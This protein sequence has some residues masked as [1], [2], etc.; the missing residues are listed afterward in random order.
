[1]ALSMKSA[2]A[3]C[4]GIALAVI[5]P[6]LSLM[7]AATAIHRLPY[8][9]P[10]WSESLLAAA[11]GIF[12]SLPEFAITGALTAL[13][14]FAFEAAV[15]RFGWTGHRFAHEIVSAAARVLLFLLSLFFGTA[16]WYPTVIAQP[17]LGGFL[18]LPTWILLSLALIPIAILSR[19]AA[20]TGRSVHLCL[21][22]LLTGFLIPLPSAL[23]PMIP[24]SGR[25]PEMVL[26]GLD[27]L[28]YDEAS[29]IREWASARNGTDYLRA[30]APALL[31]NAVWAS[32]ITG[33]YPSEHGVVQ[34]FQPLKPGQ[35]RLVSLARREGYRTVSRFSDQ[36]TCAVGT[37]SGFD[38]DLS[39][40]MGWRQLV[41]PIV[42]DSSVL[43]PLVRPLLPRLHFLASPPNMAGT[44]SFSLR[45]DLDELLHTSR[46]G[47]T[48]VAGH[49]TFMHTPSYPRYGDLTWSE[50]LRILSSPALRV[51][52]RSFDWSDS[53]RVTDAVAIHQWKRRR[54]LEEV[55]A[56][57]DRSGAIQAGSRIVLFS[58]HGD[59]RGLNDK[60]A[61]D[62]K[63]HHVL[64]TTFN[65][66]SHS[67]Q[68]ARSLVDI[69][70]LLGFAKASP[71]P[72]RVEFAVFPAHLWRDLVV[73]A[74]LA[75]SGR[76]SLDLATVDR[77]TI[78][79][80]VFEPWSPD[81]GSSGAPTT[82][83]APGTRSGRQ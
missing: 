26:L 33:D 9:S 13:V 66:V 16:L 23:R 42:H 50:T 1:M 30:V 24:T 21:F 52:D 83:L 19:A 4:L 10:P 51:R 37:D 80:L 65:L 57:V 76:V 8:Y 63:Y 67:P 58:D 40:P 22:V 64:L 15:Q 60:T 77:A 75:W 71:V 39:G 59:R 62:P 27:S 17:L 45:R 14:F 73:T 68:A 53:D 55:A 18:T 20:R 3:V 34:T 5:W 28:S 72:P 49:T 61:T 70:Y 25:P 46:P 35:E 47:P 7:N 48:F 78:R 11:A 41:L 43:L 2:R 69:G 38:D 12:L 6:A 54:L 31:T 36:L 29:P 44:Y 81:A 82:S 56:A 32:V 79:P 74:K